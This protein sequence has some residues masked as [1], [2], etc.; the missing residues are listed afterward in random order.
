M[1]LTKRP[2]KKMT[3]GSKHLTQNLRKDKDD[4][5][6]TLLPS[7]TFRLRSMIGKQTGPL[8]L[9]FIT[10]LLFWMI[11]LFFLLDLSTRLLKWPII[12]ALL[13]TDFLSLSFLKSLICHYQTM[14]MLDHFSNSWVCRLT[15][16][17][18]IKINLNTSTWLNWT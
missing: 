4:M 15:L 11:A 9:H 16:D 6:C 18:N 7:K 1:E 2:A 14:V 17:L 3:S 13:Y 8:N 12:F 5:V 10:C